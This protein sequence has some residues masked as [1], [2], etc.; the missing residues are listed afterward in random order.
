[1][2][3]NCWLGALLVSLC[4][5][6]SAAWALPATLNYQGVL[7]DSAGAP[8]TGTVTMTFALYDTSS[9]IVALWSEVRDVTVT[10]GVY[11]VQL[12]IDSPLDISLFSGAALYLGV[13]IGGEEMQP[14]AELSA[15]PF[16]MRATV[17]DAADTVA[18][19]GV[20]GIPAD[21]ADGDDNTPLS[22]AQVEAY[23]TNGPLQLA[24]GSTIVNAPYATLAQMYGEN[25]MKK[26]A[27][28]VIVALSNGDYTSP[29]TAMANV[30]TWCGPPTDSNPCLVK[31]M[32]GIYDLAGGTLSMRP[33]VDIEGSGEETTIIKSAYGTSSW[34]APGVV[35]GASHAELRF[36]TVRNT[37]TSGQFVV[38]I[39]NISTAPK[40]TQVTATA[41]GG[42][43]N[44]GVLNRSAAPTMTHV[45]AAASGGGECY[46]VY[47]SLSSA[48]IMNN[49][50][51]NA[52][53]G[54]YSYGVENTFTSSPTM[55][56]VSAAATGGTF[57]YGVENYSSSSPTM[58][59]VSAAASGGSDSCGVRNASTSSP[60]MVNVNVS[61]SGGSSSNDG[62]QNHTASS[63][64]MTNVAITASGGS[65]STGVENNNAS[66]TMT[67]VTVTASGAP[68]VYGIYSYNS[69]FAMSNVSSRATG[70]ANTFGLYNEAD[71]AVTIVADRSSFEGGT[72]SVVNTNSAVT[73]RIGG[74]K[75]TG[76]VSNVG[77]ISC[78]TSYN[79]SYA[80]LG[81]NCLP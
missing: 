32:P 37:A 10:D 41:S 19:S 16:A 23:V 65:S 67:N 33:Y 68:T 74:S 34:P 15:A 70:G 49:V 18:W 3:I 55:T 28:V 12:G 8:V 69:S 40:L 5:A 57:N 54:T 38:A 36:L 75:L 13:S 73:L 39:A 66:P 22:E 2:R 81:A 58:T 24:E 50:T 30:D 27:K 52:S 80:T 79:N 4:L 48:P 78:A 26:P 43:Y 51:A 35:N 59:N 21:L 63:P 20:T 53:G 45:T 7:A 42:T 14:R 77:T 62:V 46:G 29:V 61:A 64:T 6:T 44:Y 60:I 71:F 72:N 47:N 1:M 25:Y 31:I 11:S 9:A 56:N 76:A 17:A